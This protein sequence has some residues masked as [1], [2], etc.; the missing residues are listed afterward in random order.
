[1]FEKLVAYFSKG[2]AFTVFGPF[3]VLL[4]CGVG[5]PV[6]EDIILVTAGFLG[7]QDN[8]PLLY[9]IVLMYLGIV[10]GDS[11]IFAVGRFGG[12]RF[13]KTRLGK[14]I[15]TEEKLFKAKSAFTRWGSGVIFAARFMPGLRAPTYFSAGTLHFS[16][17]KFVLIDGF[18]ALISA[19]FFVWLGHK[20]FFLFGNDFDAIT[21]S[22][23]QFKTYFIVGGLALGLLIFFVVWYRGRRRKV[24]DA[25]PT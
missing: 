6:P 22:I 12:Q 3:V 21:H 20:A 7:A 1:V 11:I 8:I 23:A 2:A 10:G 13:L 9:T 18:A 5:L 17:I 14:K 15:I 24:T 25:S 16:Y 19:P 4:L